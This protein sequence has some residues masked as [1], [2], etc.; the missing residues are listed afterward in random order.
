MIKIRGGKYLHRQLKQ[1][2]LEITRSTK[3]VCKEG[4]FNSLGNIFNYSFLDLFGGSGSIGIEAYS[5]GANPV[6]INDKNK[7]AYKII[8]ENLKSLSITDI[9]IFNLD[10]LNMLSLLKDRNIKFDII[11][12]DPPYKM[13]INDE[14]INNILSFNIL[15]KNGIII[16]ETDYDLSPILI[17][18]Y[19]VKILKYGRSKINILRKKSWKLLYILEVLIQLQMVI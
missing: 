9:K 1:P 15:E 8:L 3:D 4:M 7:E 18:K 14:F 19:Q 11:F 6:Y 17:E 12:L 2:P 13:E 10:Y 16:A 5:R